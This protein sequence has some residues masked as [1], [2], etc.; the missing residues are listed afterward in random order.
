[1][2]NSE[3][4][5]E[6]RKLQAEWFVA[7]SIFGE[8]STNDWSKES[9][10]KYS[11]SGMF[12]GQDGNSRISWET[13]KRY[14]NENK[15]S[16]IERFEE[17]RDLDGNIIQKESFGKLKNEVLVCLNTK[18]R[19]EATELLVEHILSKNHVYTTRND[20]KEEV[21]IYC[22]GIYVPQGKT[23]I[24]EMV[25]IVL[26]EAYTNQIYNEVLSKI[27]AD[28]YIEQKE[29]FAINN[30]WEL[31]V[32]NGI[33]DLKTRELSEFTP[34][35]IFFTKLPM[36][37]DAE[38]KCEAIDRHF[39]EV[40]ATEEDAVVMEEVFG[41]LL[42]KEYRIEKAIIMLGD[43]RNG[44]GKT[45]T[46]MKNFV[47]VGGYSAVALKN[48]RED[49]FRLCDMFG[50]LVN[51]S[52]DLSNTSLK[53]TGCL[54]MLIGRDPI[55]GDRKHK[56]SVEFVN[57]A[58]IIF[59]ANEL[60]R[61]YDSTDGFWDKWV[62]FVFPFKFITQ[63]EYDTLS[64]EEQENKKII[65]P[66]HI[67]KIN[68]PEEMTGLLNRA[69]DGLDRTLKNNNYSHSPSGNDVKSWWIRKSD[70]FAAFCTD[71][72]KGEYDSFI[73]KK[74]LQSKFSKYCKAVKLNGVSPKSI[75]ATMENEFG[76][77]A[78]RKYVEVSDGSSF[79]TKTQEEVWEGVEFNEN[80][81]DFIKNLKN[82]S[83]KGNKG[84]FSTFHRKLNSLVKPKNVP[85]CTN[86]SKNDELEENQEELIKP[87]IKPNCRVLADIPDFADPTNPEKT[88]S[89]KQWD[90][91]KLSDE[92]L[93]I[94]LKDGRIER[95]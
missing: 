49:N 59:A 1:M 48:M 9:Y 63:E 58:K 18:Q 67:S 45:I 6:E 73:T 77:I 11:K 94:L 70:N 80:V 20:D 30:I 34:D 88:I 35:K 89:L 21:Y 65:D 84:G 56:D 62:P 52:G 50:K 54:K 69:L 31:P 7:Q 40:L 76:S 43:G 14:F 71:C 28:T 26:G 57:Y 25:R 33:L 27:E 22:D 75:I 81:D 74:E 87:E 5:L 16:I 4:S 41:T 91:V 53:D 85:Y 60:P 61:V 15:E 79:P 10:D 39:R 92:A 38:Q 12:M 42:L 95:I 36:K 90:E 2:V 46:L 83:N 24:R 86:L 23:Y 93:K 72:I 47:G 78:T 68:T 17:V 32:Q 51:L 3:I 19:N 37:Y 64:P 82:N 13:W 44:K 55:S 8:L 66:D 29:F